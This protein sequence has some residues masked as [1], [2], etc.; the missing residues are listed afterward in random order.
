MIAY[1]VTERDNMNKIILSYSRT[2]MIHIFKNF[3]TLFYYSYYSTNKTHNYSK[4]EETEHLHAERGGSKCLI[5]FIS[6][7][8]ISLFLNCR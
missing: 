6:Y 2:G 1:W 4:W 5:H 3:N 7:G 8:P